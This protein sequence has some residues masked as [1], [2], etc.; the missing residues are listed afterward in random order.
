GIPASP[1]SGNGWGGSPP[2]PLTVSFTPPHYASGRDTNGNG[3]YD[4][5]LVNASIRVDVADN[6]T[7]SGHLHD[8]NFTLSVFNG[9]SRYLGPGSWVVTVFFSGPA[10]NEIGRASCRESASTRGGSGQ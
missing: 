8:S 1:A 5:L 2:R 4:F 9:T 7:V 10:I 3:L 6:Y